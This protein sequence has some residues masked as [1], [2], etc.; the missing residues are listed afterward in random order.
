MTT[1]LGVESKIAFLGKV[2]NEEML[3]Y[4]HACDIFVLPSIAN[5]EAFGIVQLEAMACGKPIINTYLPTGVPWVSRNGETGIT[6][7]PADSTTLAKAINRLFE[8]SNLRKKY[9][10]NALRRVKEYFGVT[11]MIK[12]VYRVYEDVLR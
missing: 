9:H 7:P 1:K 6:V 2:D 12:D 10:R 3:A 5:S 8:D 11:R 4:Y